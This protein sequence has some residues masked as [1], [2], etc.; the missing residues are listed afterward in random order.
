M[1]KATKFIRTCKHCDKVFTTE[2]RSKRVCPVCYS[3]NTR[4][5]IFTLDEYRKK[6]LNKWLINKGKDNAI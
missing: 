2:L 3:Q 5:K 6:E 1:K 4:R